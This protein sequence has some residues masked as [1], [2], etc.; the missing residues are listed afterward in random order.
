KSGAR[1]SEKDHAPAKIEGATILRFPERLLRFLDR[2]ETRQ[3]HVG[4][5]AFAKPLDSMSRLSPLPPLGEQCRKPRGQRQAAQS[6]NADAK[7]YHGS[8]HSRQSAL[9]RLC[10]SRVR[11]PHV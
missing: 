6:R 7:R 5:V 1:C 8:L 3:P 9:S 2:V 10:Y 4:E 11:H